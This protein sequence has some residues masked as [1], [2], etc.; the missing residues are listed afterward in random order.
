MNY[1]TKALLKFLIRNEKTLNEI[2]LKYF[3]EP[4]ENEKKR[5]NT[6][7]HTSG[8]LEKTHLEI[9]Q[10]WVYGNVIGGLLE[11]IEDMKNE[12]KE[13]EKEVNKST[14]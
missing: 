1:K 4:I 8:T 9:G 3:K 2:L 5:I 6:Y 10:M 11:H 14:L 13:I 7:G 12:E